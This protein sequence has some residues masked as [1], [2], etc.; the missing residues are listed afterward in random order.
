[1]GHFIIFKN[2]IITAGPDCGIVFDSVNIKIVNGFI[3]NMQL[4]YTTNTKKSLIV[5]QK[6]GHDNYTAHSFNWDCL[7]CE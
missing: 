3:I 1:L 6:L 4:L 2:R 7:L 5:S